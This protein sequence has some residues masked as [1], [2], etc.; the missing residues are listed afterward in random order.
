[1]GPRKSVAFNTVYR[2]VGM[3]PSNRPFK[4]NDCHDMFRVTFTICCVAVANYLE[5]FRFSWSVRSVD[6]IDYIH[7]KPI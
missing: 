1:M 3:H 5:L 4:D 7:F 2:V 6:R